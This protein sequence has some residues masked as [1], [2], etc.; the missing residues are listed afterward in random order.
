MGK[1]T[2]WYPCNGIVLSNKKKGTIDTSY[3]VDGFLE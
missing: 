1:Q 3:S 2:V